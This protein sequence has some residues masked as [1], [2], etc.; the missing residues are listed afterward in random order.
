MS[1]KYKS[2]SFL[3]PNELNTSANTANDTGINSLYSM[4]F[5]GNSGS[6]TLGGLTSTIT[7]GNLLTI[8]CWYYPTNVG[9][10]DYIIGSG[11]T[12]YGPFNGERNTRNDRIR[13]KK[14]SGT[15]Q[16]N[17]NTKE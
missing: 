3:L 17:I 6:A 4:S 9:S 1:A 5:P 8:S 11:S 12:T 7:Q 14:S 13:W 2:P 15:N 10:S 16:I